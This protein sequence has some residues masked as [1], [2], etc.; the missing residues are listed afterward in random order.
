[1]ETKPQIGSEQAE[2]IE[3]C[4]LFGGLDASNGHMKKCSCY[5]RIPALPRNCSDAHCKQLNTTG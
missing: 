3:L 2:G 4:W 5:R 1:M